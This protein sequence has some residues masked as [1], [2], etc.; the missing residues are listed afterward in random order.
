MSRH[1]DAAHGRPG[2][3]VSFSSG[4][5]ASALLAHPGEVANDPHLT[6]DEKRS[7]LAS[8]LS[9]AHAVPNA[10]AW[11]QLDDGAFA[12]AEDV[13]EALRSLDDPP[14]GDRQEPAGSPRRSP[15]HRRRRSVRW[16]DGAIRRKRR[17]DDDDDPPPTP[18]TSRLPPHHPFPVGGMEPVLTELA[19]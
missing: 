13:L 19:A 17:D 10:P 8:W 18:V 11:R 15:F 12:R 4:F 7:L 2:L 1:I 9:D 16:I 3:V 14:G 6:L 5:G